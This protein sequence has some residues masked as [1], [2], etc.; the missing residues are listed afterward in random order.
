MLFFFFVIAPHVKAFGD[1]A[2]FWTP[3]A[4]RETLWYWLYLQNLHVA[5]RASS[6][7]IFLGIAW[8][9]SIEEQFYLSGRSSSCSRAAED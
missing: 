1:P 7:I 5:F 6:T 8:T 2:L 3:G 9:L 4:E